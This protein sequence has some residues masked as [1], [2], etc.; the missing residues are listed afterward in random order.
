MKF[1][2]LRECD[3]GLQVIERLYIQIVQRLYIEVSVKKH[4]MWI[5][6]DVI[7]EYD[8]VSVKAIPTYASDHNQLYDILAVLSNFCIAKI[9]L[10]HFYQ[11]L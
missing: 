1:S 2:R 3:I 11:K 6:N 8:G 10:F 4:E 7:Y 5:L 9:V